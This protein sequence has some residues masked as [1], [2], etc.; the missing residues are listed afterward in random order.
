M[1]SRVHAHSDSRKQFTQFLVRVLAAQA[2]D[3]LGWLLATA[4]LFTFL[5]TSKFTYSRT[6]AIRNWRWK[7]KTRLVLSPETGSF[8]NVVCVCICIGVGTHEESVKAL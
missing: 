7:M 4:G 1:L 5:I 8:N 6:E 3:V 2:S